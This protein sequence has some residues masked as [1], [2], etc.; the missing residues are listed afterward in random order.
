MEKLTNLTKTNLYNKRY[1]IKI[2]G[3]R[4]RVFKRRKMPLVDKYKETQVTGGHF[5]F[6]R[7]Y[8]HISCGVCQMT[9]MPSNNSTFIIALEKACEDIGKTYSLNPKEIF[10]YVF[11]AYLNAQL[12]TK[13]VLLSDNK[14]V[15]QSKIHS[16]L[17]DICQTQT[18]YGTN[19]NSHN[20][21][22]VWAY[23][24]GDDRNIKKKLK[25]KYR[26]NEKKA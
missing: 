15:G 18:P 8:A 7:S 10:K 5:N 24:L 23:M 12:R 14:R 9:G 13:F 17:D 11:H 22:K 2:G 19:P 21:I 3:D 6:N 4:I 26:K 16:V 1:R 25:E 20:S